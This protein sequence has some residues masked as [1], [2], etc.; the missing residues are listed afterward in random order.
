MMINISYIWSIVYTSMYEIC[1]KL[2][3]DIVD[4]EW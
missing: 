1:K 2:N 3:M 4:R